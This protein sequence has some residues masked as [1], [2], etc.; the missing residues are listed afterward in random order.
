M[1]L[2][3]DELAVGA[4]ARLI[5]QTEIFFRN[6]FLVAAV[7][8]HQPDIV[9]ARAVG[10]E[11]DPFAVGRKTRLMLIS[12]AFGDPRRGAALDRHRI[13]VAEQVEG[14][15][16]PVGR[17]IDI[18]PAPFVDRKLSLSRRKAGGRI[19]VPFV[20]FC[21]GGGRRSGRRRALRPYRSRT[22]Q[23]RREGESDAR[24]EIIPV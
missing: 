12:E 13:D 15:R 14:D 4:P 24:H 5:E 11:R 9:A 7:A 3:D 18:H 6:L 10:H 16:P 19:D 2:C 22:S 17:D 1:L 8:V 23:S 21:V 20:L